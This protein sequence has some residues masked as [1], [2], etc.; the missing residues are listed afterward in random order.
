MRTTLAKLDSSHLTLNESARLRCEAALE[1]KDRGEYDKAREVMR[2]FWKTFGE[3]PN[4]EG[5]SREMAAE[6]LLHVGILT[7]W[8]GSKNQI[9]ESSQIASDLISESITY[10]EAERDVKKVAAARAELG[11]C[12]WREGALDE[13]RIMFTEALKKLTAEGNTRAN[14][15]LGLAEVERATSR[16]NDAMAILTDN[17]RVFQ[18]I[19]NHTTKGHYHNQR[20]M[21]LRSLATAEKRNDYFEQAIKEYQ[22][23]DHQFELARNRVYRGYVKNNVG[24]LLFKL[25]RFKVAHDYLTEARR[26]AVNAK[27]KILVAQ[28]DDSLAK[29]FIATNKLKEAETAARRSVSVLDKSSHSNTLADSLITYGIVLARLHQ[30]DQAQ[31]IFQRA[32]ELAHNAGVLSTAGIAALTMIEEIDHLSDE[33]LSHAY[34]QAGEWLS[35]CQSQELWFRFKI[36]GKKVVRGLRSGSQDASGILFNKPCHMPKEVL[37]FERRLISQAL[38]TANGRVTHAAKWLGIGRQRLAYIIETRHPD[39]LK[40]R[41]PV[42][43]RPRK[44]SHSKHR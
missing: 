19:T 14:A 22:R 1:L 10:W 18:K 43:R 25:G 30:T 4:T 32:I 31:F 11:M 38:A 27:D 35:T 3:R 39:L 20:A 41:T 9:K 2:P 8:I 42:R 29:L 26:L 24:F 40:E 21:V 5:L 12:Y 13:A 37:Q 15:L 16:Y 34:E 17:A 33:T 6:L 7:R 23:A 44:V 28:F 36:A